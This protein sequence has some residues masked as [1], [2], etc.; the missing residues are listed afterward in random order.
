MCLYRAF[1][2]WIR[3]RQI[4]VGLE[5]KI[6]CWISVNFYV[7]WEKF[8]SYPHPVLAPGVTFTENQVIVVGGFDIVVGRNVHRINRVRMTI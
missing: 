2:F 4:K 5:L 6:L 7:G 8:P 3:I 1:S